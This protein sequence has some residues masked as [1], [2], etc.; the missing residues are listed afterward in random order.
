MNRD[1]IRKAVQFEPKPIFIYR[2]THITARTIVA[3]KQVL[4]DC[5]IFG[6]NNDDPF[7]AG[8]PFWLW[9]HFLKSVPVYDLVF[10][11]RKHNLHD[12]IKFGAKRVELLRSWFVPE[13]NHSVS[14]SGQDKSNYECD[15]VLIGHYE[16]DGRLQYLEEVGGLERSRCLADSIEPEYFAI[17]CA[18]KPSAVDR[19]A[20]SNQA[21]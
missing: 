14:L 1:L 8:H 3:L 6:Y 21:W 15:V 7:A 19:C 10:A 2:G 20:S 4:H 12:L 9:R 11:Y 13:I 16:N 5:K 18:D 17:P